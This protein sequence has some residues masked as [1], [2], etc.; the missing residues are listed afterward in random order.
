MPTPKH[1]PALTPIDT[2]S[3]DWPVIALCAVSALLLLLLAE[4]T[5]TSTGAAVL[6]VCGGFA[7]IVLL[8]KGRKQQQA[9]LQQLQD[10]C[11]QQQQDQQ[12]DD[13]FSHNFVELCLHA[14]PIWTKQIESSRHQ[15]EQAIIALSQRFSAI[16]TQLEEAVAASENTSSATTTH[17]KS[18]AFAVMALSQ[19]ELTEVINSLKHT[20]RSRDEM[21]TQITSL[22]NY[23]GELR[24]M[25]TQVAA[26]AQQTNLLALNAAI[27]AARAGEA[28]RGFAVV[29]D[30]VR[31]LSS[32][33][34]ETG[35]K[36]SSTVDIINGAINNVVKVAGE[37]AE[38]DAQSVGKSEVSIQQVL[39]R[40]SDVTRQMSD[41]T[42][43][44]QAE[45]N[46][47][48]NEISE[49][50][51]A[52]QFQDRVSQIMVHVRSNIDELHHYLETYEQNP[53]QRN[54]LDT[55]TWLKKMEQTY[56]TDEQRQNHYGTTAESKEHEITF[57]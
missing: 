8:R 24:T 56:A 48:R 26:I 35:Q 12:A 6:I 14:M 25:A 38:S 28:G 30:A 52:L 42:A 36:M 37:A 15:T 9:L 55:S 44:L 34:S 53:Q 57:F 47:I 2:L 27:E 7:T 54:T 3:K 22:T 16:Y 50:L 10:A 49:V 31:T 20:Q 41:T 13:A 5:L 4:L 45:S 39:D 1:D 51:V 17:G 11:N 23:T 43:Q 33:S 19:T 21:L 29:A 32:L 40:F 46:D 18:G